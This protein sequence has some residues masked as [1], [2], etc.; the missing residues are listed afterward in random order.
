MAGH[1]RGS[2][3]GGQGMPRAVAMAAADY[4]NGANFAFMNVRRAHHGAGKLVE[5]FGT[6]KLK[7]LFLKRMYSG[8]W[9]APCC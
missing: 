5:S 1:D 2:G 8:E 6:E 3:L 9:T 7:K 4:L